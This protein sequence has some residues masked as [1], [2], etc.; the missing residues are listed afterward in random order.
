MRESLAS[1]DRELARGDHRAPLV[2][3]RL[4]ARRQEIADF[5]AA[6]VPRNDRTDSKAR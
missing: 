5:L 4:G 6:A 1:Y 3:H 2:R